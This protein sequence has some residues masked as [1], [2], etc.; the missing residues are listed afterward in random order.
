MPTRPT[1]G[2]HPVELRVIGAFQTRF[3]GHV[4]TLPH[5]AERLIAVV[6]L[7]G[8][9]ARSYAGRLLWPDA[10]AARARANLRA[11]LARSGVAGAGIV[12][13][14]GEVLS[15]GDQVVLDVDTARAWIDETIYDSSQ[16][17]VSPP[18][19]T[20]GR[21]LLA[22]W[23]DEWLDGPR[24]RLQMLQA[25]ALETAAERLL[26]ANQP[27]EAMPYA[28]TAVELQPWSES[29]NRLLIEIHA[30]RGDPSNALRRY[31]RFCR[32]LE[33]ELGVQPGP[34]MIAAIRQLYPFGNPLTEK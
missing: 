16:A 28:M 25:Q 5:S 13:I 4:R 20:V 15:L 32:A 11:A 30:R 21:P 7:I 8:P 27:A 29:A 19:P 1:P 18:P 23:D 22:G 14:S 10:P 12:H 33:L 26:A 6:A 34:D 24:E 31:R 3:D 17:V 9:L 2:A